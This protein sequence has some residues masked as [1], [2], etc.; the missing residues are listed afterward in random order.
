MNKPGDTARQPASAAAFPLDRL[1]TLRELEQM[2]YG[3][4]SANL[5]KVR[6]GELPA[7]VVGNKFKIRENDLHRLFRAFCPHQDAGFTAS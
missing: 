5:L 7:V 3:S 6:S 4:R 2:G 1:Y